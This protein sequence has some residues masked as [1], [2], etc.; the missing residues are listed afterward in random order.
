MRY[1]DSTAHHGYYTLKLVPCHTQVDKVKSHFI[2]PARETIAELH[3]PHLFESAAEHLEFS[4]TLLADNKYLFRVAEQ[5]KGGERGPNQ[6]QSESIS[7]NEW[8]ASTLLAV[9]GNP[10]VDRHPIL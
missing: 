8:L 2:Q 6:M 3:D 5:V 9:R 4:A 1:A 7:A 10:A